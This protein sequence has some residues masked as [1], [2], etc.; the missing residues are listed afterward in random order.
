MSSKKKITNPPPQK[1][2]AKAKDKTHLIVIVSIQKTFP[3]FSLAHKKES[4]ACL[5]FLRLCLPC[6]KKLSAKTIWKSQNSR[7]IKVT[8]DCC[9]FTKYKNFFKA[10]K[11]TNKTLC[12][13]NTKMKNKH[14]SLPEANRYPRWKQVCV[15][16]NSALKSH[17]PWSFATNP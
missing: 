5:R 2:F 12:N 10:L 4:K 6:I 7:F 9:F 15:K 8:I 17:S 1:T 16:I 13:N 14:K 11:Q 3:D